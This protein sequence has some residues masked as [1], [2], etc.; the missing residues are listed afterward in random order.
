M[1]E[2]RKLTPEERMERF[3][4]AIRD[5]ATLLMHPDTW[6]EFKRHLEKPDDPV[7]VIVGLRATEIPVIPSEFMKPG[8][9]MAVKPKA[10]EAEFPSLWPASES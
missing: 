5:G 4:A 3:V 10:F 6:A 2:S 7:S 8:D 1:S 9:M